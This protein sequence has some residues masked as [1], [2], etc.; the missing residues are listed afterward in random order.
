MACILKRAF[1]NGVIRKSLRPGAKVMPVLQNITQSSQTLEKSTVNV[2]PCIR[3]ADFIFLSYKNGVLGLGFYYMRP[4]TPRTIQQPME[5]E[6]KKWKAIWDFESRLRE[7]CVL[8]TWGHKESFK[9]KI[10]TPSP[11]NFLKFL[12]I[13]GTYVYYFEIYEILVCVGL[14]GLLFKISRMN[15]RVIDVVYWVGRL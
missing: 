7:W 8:G 15:L 4:L 9:G 6:R 12:L 3:H 5:R 10:L 14:M 2:R 1:R 13:I 11:F